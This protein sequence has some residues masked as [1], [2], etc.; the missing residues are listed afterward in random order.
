RGRAGTMAGDRLPCGQS[1]RFLELRE[2]DGDGGLAD[3]RGMCEIGVSP[4]MVRRPWIDRG[5]H[6]MKAP[7]WLFRYGVAVLVVVAAVASLYIPV[8]GRGLG[9]ILFLDVLIRS[10]S[11]GLGPGLLTTALILGV[12]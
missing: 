7:P 9:A 5:V 11:G 2:G 1:V 10:W 4:S 12:A 8:I 3:A 6:K